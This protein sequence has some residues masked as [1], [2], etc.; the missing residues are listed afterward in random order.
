VVA[1]RDT[2]SSICS[3]IL[4]SPVTLTRKNGARPQPSAPVEACHTGINS[5]RGSVTFST[6]FN[7]L[8]SAAF[9]YHPSAIVR[10]SDVRR[11]WQKPARP[12]PSW[13]RNKLGRAA[14]AGPMV[15]RGVRSPF[16]FPSPRGRCA[17]WLWQLF[18]ER[19]HY[20]A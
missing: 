5:N 10:N 7:S 18:C 15:R 2:T 11:H 9:T 4:S 14:T 8:N 12:H 16:Q 3:A 19:R 1:P 20:R 13:K 17:V 6:L